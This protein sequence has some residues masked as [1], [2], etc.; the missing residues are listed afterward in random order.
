MSGGYN[1]TTIRNAI[2]VD[3]QFDPKH[4]KHSTYVQ[5]LARSKS[6]VMTVT[7]NGQLS[8]FQAEEESVL[9]G[10]PNTTVI[11]NDLAEVLLGLFVP[12]NQLLALFQQH[13]SHYEAKR[14]ACANVWA[15]VEPTLS[16]YNRN[17]ASNIEL[18]WKSKE[19]SRIDAALR[20]SMNKSQGSFDSDVDEIEQADLD[21]SNKEPL[22]TLMEDF[23]AETLVVA[24]YSIAMS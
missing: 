14:D 13:A 9:G 6:Q 23:S 17:F 4:P 10:H 5:R 7:F 15:I 2:A 20:R 24:Y 21:S 16:L 12:W 22:D 8:E 18:L 1:L 19:D 3:L 11:E